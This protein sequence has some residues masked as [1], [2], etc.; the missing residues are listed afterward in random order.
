M[1]LTDNEMDLLT[2]KLDIDGLTRAIE[3]A[4][5]EKLAQGVVTPEPAIGWDFDH[6]TGYCRYEAPVPRYVENQYYTADQLRAYGAA[7]RLKALEDC[8]NEI[9][10]WANDQSE[11][12]AA[13]R[14]LK[15][16]A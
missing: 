5:V 1:L 4:V 12:K 3:R 16:E 10:G 15:G 2:G 9:E 14:A 11:L 8:L 13:I 7:C 6:Y